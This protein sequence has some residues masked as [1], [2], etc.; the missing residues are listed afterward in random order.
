MTRFGASLERGLLERF[1]AFVQEARH[2]NRSAA[3]REII[4]DHLVARN[5]HARSGPIA[6][7]VSLVYHNRARGVSA[8]LQSVLTRQRA[9]VVGDTSYYVHD[10]YTVRVIILHGMAPQVRAVADALLGC[11]GVVHGSATPLM[12]G[13]PCK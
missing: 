8:A 5:W 11:K 3:L 1:D 6:A 12:P 9:Y 13:P 4:R 7:V 10:H 2:R